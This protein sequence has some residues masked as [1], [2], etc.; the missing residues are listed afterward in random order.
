VDKIAIEITGDSL[1]LSNDLINKALDPIE[2]VKSRNV[3][4]GPAPEM[5]ELSAKN[6]QKFLEKE[7]KNKG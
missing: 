2:N 3:L 4:G 1:S 6:L 5:V 7:Y